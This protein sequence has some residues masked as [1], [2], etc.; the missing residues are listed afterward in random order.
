MSRRPNPGNSVTRH[1]TDVAR[2]GYRGHQAMCVCGWFGP[3]RALRIEARDDAGMHKLEGRWQLPEAP[4]PDDD[5]YGE[6]LPLFTDEG[7]R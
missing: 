4:R 1:R 5:R 6:Q 3:T 2:V 7:D